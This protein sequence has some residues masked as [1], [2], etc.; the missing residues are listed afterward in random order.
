MPRLITSALLALL[1]SSPAHAYK[2]DKNWPC[3]Q[4]K[5]EKLSAGQMWPNLTTKADDQSW[6]DDKTIT[7]L[8]EQLLPRRTTLEE[9]EKIIKE[10]AEKHK[11]PNLNI[12]LEKTYLGLLTEINTIR[13][14]I[15][16]GIGRFSNRQK[17]LVKRITESRHKI[18]DYEKK[19]IAG[20][21]TKEEDSQLVKLEQ[22]LEWDQRIHE[23]REQSLEFVCE[24]PVLLEQRL[25]TLA[26]QLQK[27]TNS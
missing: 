8:V 12:A 25:F 4:A 2:E 5:V 23:E 16:S 21:L 20:T 6:R 9:T 26:R 27:Y 3:I 19:D 15:I 10:F 7:A 13:A 18:T 1:I 22:A 17:V 14:E 11:G 24:A